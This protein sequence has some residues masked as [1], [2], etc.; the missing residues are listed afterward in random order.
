MKT[1]PQVDVAKFKSWAEAAINTQQEDIGR[2]SRSVDRIERDMRLFK[3]FM[4]EVRTELASNR[5]LQEQ[6]SGEG[7]ASVSAELDAL[8]QQ[9]NSNPRPV[10]R[11]SFEISNRSLDI[12]AKD[13]QLVG[14]K[15]D[16]ID[17]LKR[18]L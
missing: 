16:E 11:G 18:E 3:D 2:L 9:V 14:R 8:R 4:E 12:I 6:E 15:V 7:L 13:V 5:Q 1:P 17:E 10:S